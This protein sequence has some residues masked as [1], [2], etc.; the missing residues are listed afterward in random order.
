LIA[1]TNQRGEIVDLELGHQ[2]GAVLLDR[3]HADS[4]PLGDFS[5]LLTF[6]QKL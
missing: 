1:T 2:T 4:K 3:L 5:I 6:R